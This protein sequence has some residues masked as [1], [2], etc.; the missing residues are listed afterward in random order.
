MLLEQLAKGG[1]GVEDAGAVVG[2]NRDGGFG[3][4]EMVALWMGVG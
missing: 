1:D 2:A 3:N 4:L